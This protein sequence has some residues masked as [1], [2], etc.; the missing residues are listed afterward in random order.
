MLGLRIVLGQLFNHIGRSVRAA[1]KA[2]R[3]IA[4]SARCGWWHSFI[5]NEILFGS[6]LAHIGGGSIRCPKGGLHQ[7]QKY[8]SPAPWHRHGR[9]SKTVAHQRIPLHAARSPEPLSGWYTTEI[10]SRVGAR[11][12]RSKAAWGSQPV[13][14]TGRSGPGKRLLQFGW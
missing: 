8:R 14:S 5:H 12:Y 10:A 9:M 1:E 3:G 11:A 7:F 2:I 4:V 13:T 6:H